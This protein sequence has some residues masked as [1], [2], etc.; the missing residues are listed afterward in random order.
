MSTGMTDG[1]RWLVA[2]GF[3]WMAYGLIV[4]VYKLALWLAAR[5]M[6]GHGK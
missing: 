1:E 3:V 6:E 4:A 5:R 2:C